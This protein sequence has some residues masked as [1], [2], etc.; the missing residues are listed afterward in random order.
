M[1]DLL[2]DLRYAFRSLIKTSGFT[3][4]TVL[5]LGLGIGANTAVF[6]VVN[7][8]LLQPLPVD[9]PDRLA[10]IWS[11]YANSSKGLVTPD[12]Y[13]DIRDHNRSFQTLAAYTGL[14]TTLTGKEGAEM[15][16]LSIVTSNLFTTLGARPALGRAF[17]TAEDEPGQ[18][19][20]AILSYGL[21]QRRFGGDAGI[22]GRAIEESGTAITVV[23]VMPQGFS[24]SLQGMAG[25]PSSVEL[26][27][28]MGLLP[29]QS[30][31]R[32]NHC[33]TVVGRRKP[34]SLLPAAQA[35]LS[36]IFAQLAQQY[37][38]TNKAETARLVPLT[39]EAVGSY[40]SA[41]FILLAAV[42]AVLLI[43][44][45]NV[46]N[47]M[48]SRTSGRRR[49]IAIR[50]AL[51][52]S[53]FRLARQLFAESLLLAVAGGLTG[54]LLAAWGVDA[55]R[56][57]APGD[58]P[59]LAQSGLTRAVGVFGFVATI[60]TVILFGTAPVM[61]LDDFQHSEGLRESSRAHSAGR[62]S[63][64]FR[65]A[66]VISQIAMALLLSMGASLLIRSFDSLMHVDLGF[67]PDN[68]LAFSVPLF[69]YRS[70][71]ARIHFAEQVLEK[72]RAMPGVRSVGFSNRI[73]LGGDNMAASVDIEGRVQPPNAAY[74][75][76]AH[77]RSITP[78]YFETLGVDLES[79]RFPADSDNAH[80]V[81]AI[82][83]NEAAARAFWP[84]QEALGKRVKIADQ[85]W[86]TITP[87]NGAPEPWLTVLGVVRNVKHDSLTAESRPEIFLP[88]AQRP[89]IM[90]TFVVRSGVQP[91]Y[92]V[93]AITAAVHSVNN[94][95]PVTLVHTMSK[96]VADS[97][98]QPRFRAILLGIFA[99]LA[100]V[101]AAAGVY[102]V[103]SY[104]V[105]QRTREIGLR[106][107]LGASRGQVL[108]LIFREQTKLLLAG[109]GIGLA[110][111]LA[112]MQFLSGLLFGVKSG[113]LASIAISMAVISAAALLAAYLP[114]RRAA[115]LDPMVVLRED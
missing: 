61:R 2:L 22:L 113:D 106:V 101:L 50:A 7:A 4:I 104:S 39:E 31:G 14:S 64:R 103:T 42:G 105:G 18:P 45:S 32:T 108:H 81:P 70:G 91:E 19:H 76:Q 80:A 73:P 75:P 84:G 9:D 52:A 20:T 55:L 100:L 26:W 82:W 90:A 27:M 95:L 37:P 43:A 89:W 92:L 38:A 48:L 79:G 78:G 77:A 44:C 29:Y 35:E 10:V 68:V 16:R 49:E 83:I 102:G 99:V 51:G 47:L 69:S 97:V 62:E 11:N 5:V 66:L 65:G 1:T 13:R 96:A 74:L 46:A 86:S 94:D 41:L 21:W 24:G 3:V 115:L 36:T 6:S 111:W 110:G 58:I 54:L 34:D 87:T 28:P 33:L 56:A 98:A 107:A 67:R 93:A 53:R 40:R 85:A 112:S 60:V 15:I 30:P 88:F 71:E 25:D 17:S 63:R 8:V 114:A 12:D 59:R 23:G 72:V 109:V 57:L